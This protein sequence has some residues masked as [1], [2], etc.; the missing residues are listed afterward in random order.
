MHELAWRVSQ[1]PGKQKKKRRKDQT[2]RPTQARGKL[3]CWVGFLDFSRVFF[4][5]FFEKFPCK[6]APTYFMATHHSSNFI[7]VFALPHFPSTADGKP[8]AVACDNPAHAATC[9]HSEW[10]THTRRPHWHAALRKLP[11]LAAPRVLGGFG[12]EQLPG[13]AAARLRRLPGHP[14]PQ[15]RKQWVDQHQHQHCYHHQQQW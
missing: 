7:S 10:S 9:A 13:H 1:R 5:I 15:R 14:K 6:H 11:E 12:H 8:S 4:F 2:E 3:G